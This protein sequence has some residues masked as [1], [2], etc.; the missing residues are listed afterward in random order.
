MPRP[1]K[2]ETGKSD[3]PTRAWDPLAAGSA[4]LFWAKIGGNGGYFVAV[5]ILARGLGPAGRG[6]VAFITVTALV[7]AHMA[8]LGVGE[9]TTVL[10]A[11]DRARRPVL[12]ANALAYFLCSGF[13]AAT[14]A[15][16]AL[17]LSGVEPAGVGTPELVIL[18][19]GIV[20]CAAG[21]AGYSFLLG[22]ERLRQLASVTGSASWVYAAVVFVLWAGPGLTVRG[23]ALAWAVTEAVRA[24]ALAT[25]SRRRTALAWPSRQL[26]VEEIGFGLRLWVGSLARFLNFRTDQIVM[27]FLATEAAL[28]I[29]AVAVNVSEV[30]LY[31][32]SSAATALLPVIARTE[33]ARRGQETLRA[34]RSVVL[35]TAAGVVGA[36]LLG[37]ILLPIVFGD[38][39]DESIIPFLWLLPGTFGFAASAVFS[40]ALVGSSSPGLSSLGPLVSL[41]VGFALDL[42][43]IPHYAATGAAVAASTAF[44]VGGATALFIYR[45]VHPFGWRSLLVPHRGDLD[46]LAALVEPLVRAIPRRSAA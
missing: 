14:L 11:R 5:L 40:N 38:A 18:A 30:L 34:F 41:A 42:A 33:P 28:G 23:A 31:L 25:L 32:P 36:A 4:N 26:L 8:G 12:L 6:T 46:V 17:S 39:F 24:T 7:V 37:P 45:R 27:G 13:V 43:L 9:A 15:F 35:V 1:V 29:Y 20:S 2:A 19:L 10:S 44:L 16:L 3:A 21:E 22:T